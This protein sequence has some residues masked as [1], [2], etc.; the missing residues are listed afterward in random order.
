MPQPISLPLAIAE[1][2]MRE[3][4]NQWLSGL[5][6]VISLETASDGQI[7]VLFKVVAGDVTGQ[8]EG[9]QHR[10]L[11]R[12]QA[13]KVEPQQP[14]RSPSYRRRFLRRAA[15]RAAAA[16]ALVMKQYS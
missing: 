14:C 8:H 7:H 3:F 15:A 12:G 13:G 2:A 16:E 4:C 10:E 1:K 9:A 11:V 6:P 5:Q